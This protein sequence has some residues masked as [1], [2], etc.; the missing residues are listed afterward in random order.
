MKKIDP[1]NAGLDVQSIVEMVTWKPN[2]KR[3]VEYCA[4]YGHNPDP[5]IGIK[6]SAPLSFIWLRCCVR[7]GLAYFENQNMKD[8]DESK[9]DQS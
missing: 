5:N 3:F 7:C 8:S 2:P 4:E 1:I 6:A 9:G